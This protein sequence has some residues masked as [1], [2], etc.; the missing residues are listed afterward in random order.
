M[1]EIRSAEYCYMVCQILITFSRVV[2]VSRAH[3][4]LEF[5]CTVYVTCSDIIEGHTR[6]YE[7]ALK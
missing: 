1:L 2:I 5:L 7:I 3:Y 6:V 4:I